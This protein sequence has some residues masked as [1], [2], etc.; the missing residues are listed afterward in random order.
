MKRTMSTIEKI[1]RRAMVDL[2]LTNTGWERRP[3]YPNSYR[4]VP[5]GRPYT[6]HTLTV[7]N[8][9]IVKQ[10]TELISRDKRSHGVDTVIVYGIPAIKARPDDAATIRK[11]RTMIEDAGY[12]VGR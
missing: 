8:G 10:A 12:T 1:L 11:Y 3:S 2:G 7:I 9:R 5:L 6:S 4:W